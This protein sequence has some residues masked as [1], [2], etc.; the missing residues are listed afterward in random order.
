MCHLCGGPGSS[1][2]GGVT[3]GG[4]ILDTFEHCG[5]PMQLQGILG[6]AKRQ[7]LGTWGVGLL[8]AA[9]I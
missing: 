8:S 5:N 1:G 7:Q 3:Q 2:E 9:R 4:Y 6:A